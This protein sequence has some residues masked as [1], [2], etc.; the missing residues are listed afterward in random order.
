MPG[1][2]LLNTLLKLA[3]KY[4]LSTVRRHPVL[5]AMDEGPRASGACGGGR[6]GTDVAA[7]LSPHLHADHH[8]TGPAAGTE[9]E[10]QE[11][12]VWSSR[13]NFVH[14]CVRCY[15]SE[16]IRLFSSQTSCSIQR[17]LLT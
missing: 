3:M 16:D 7:A 11:P 8:H 13:V 4:I 2:D 10:T 1:I 17:L 15:V 14:S 6:A 9:A 12:R 5:E